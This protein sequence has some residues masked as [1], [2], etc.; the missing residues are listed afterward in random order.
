MP[1]DEKENHKPT[2]GILVVHGPEIRSLG[3]SG[4]IKKLAERFRI[5]IWTTCPGSE[6]FAS[7]SPYVEIKAI[8]IFENNTRSKFSDFLYRLHLRWYEKSGENKWSYA[9]QKRSSQTRFFGRLK[10]QL[11]NIISTKSIIY[12]L[13]IIEGFFENHFKKSEWNEEFI[14]ND[15]DVL[16]CGNYF[17]PYVLDAIKTANSLH[18]KTYVALHSWK[19]CYVH[20]RLPLTLSGIFL[21]SKTDQIHFK[22]WNPWVNYPFH[23]TGS[24]H[25]ETVR[26]AKIMPVQLFEK[27]SG[28]DLSRPYICYTM[29]A[30]D[31]VPD[32]ELIIDEISKRLLSSFPEVQLLIRNNPMNSNH[33]FLFSKNFNVIM[34]FPHYEWK[35]ELNWA[36]PFEDDAS[37][38]ASTI[39]YSICN[40]SLPSTVTVEFLEFNRPIINIVFDSKPLG[41]HK[42]SNLR[43]WNAPFYNQVQNKEGVYPVFSYE[44][45]EQ[46]V[47]GVISKTYQVHTDS[48]T[49]R[50]PSTCIASTITSEFSK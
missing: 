36:P 22:K 3:Y 24:L 4:L 11:L 21:W 9:F 8:P 10:S 16:L 41:M 30:M 49:P 25:L 38:W 32:E 17:G 33:D 35:K 23:I 6:V 29:A 27:I 48:S 20:P 34:Q 44:G 46:A 45:L 14:K 5:L 43:Y 15:V 18:I 26:T 7:F 13:S 1:L 39:Y 2:L 37:L 31:A 42:G 50:K 28:L 19:D 47:R 12:T 40:I